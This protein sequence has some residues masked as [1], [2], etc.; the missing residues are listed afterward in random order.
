MTP[1]I[2]KE[3]YS[4][5]LRTMKLKIMQQSA[6]LTRPVALN[7]VATLT[8]THSFILVDLFTAIRTVQIWI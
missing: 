4:F 3:K 5:S 7:V 8:E 6:T 1:Y 2:E